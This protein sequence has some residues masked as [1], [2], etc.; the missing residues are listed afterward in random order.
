MVKSTEWVFK[1]DVPTAISV[2][3]EDEFLSNTELYEA[4]LSS[5]DVYKRQVNDSGWIFAHFAGQLVYCTAA[6]RTAPI[7]TER[8][9]AVH[10]TQCAEVGRKADISDF[11]RRSIQSAQPFQ[12]PCDLLFHAYSPVWPQPAPAGRRVARGERGTFIYYSIGMKK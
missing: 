8:T 9:A 3:T 6:G 7:C 4:V 5:I 1:P 2:D 10:F 11:D 12:F